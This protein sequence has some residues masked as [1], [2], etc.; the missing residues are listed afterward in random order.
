M[1]GS[2]VMVSYNKHTHNQYFGQLIIMLCPS[3]LTSSVG[4]GQELGRNAGVKVSYNTPPP[5]NILVRWSCCVPHAWLISYIGVWQGTCEQCFLDYKQSF[6][7]Y[8][9]LSL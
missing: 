6:F 9:L 1:F 7:K 8:S 5:I 3:W 2:D 4:V